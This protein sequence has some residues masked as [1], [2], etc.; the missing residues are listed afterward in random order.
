MV[1]SV[2]KGMVGSGSVRAEGIRSIWAHFPHSRSLHYTPNP[3]SVRL[4]GGA[5]IG[6]FLGWKEQDEHNSRRSKL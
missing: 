6:H 5:A 2:W 1:V 3:N 4:F